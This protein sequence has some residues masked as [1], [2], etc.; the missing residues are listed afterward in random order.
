[1]KTPLRAFTTA[2]SL[3]RITARGETLL[4]VCQASGCGSAAVGLLLLQYTG[5]A[6][7]R[8]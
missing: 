8:A 2:G 7:D 4:V 1:M 6:F 3:F 5:Y